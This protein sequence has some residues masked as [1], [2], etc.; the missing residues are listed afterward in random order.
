[1]STPD[2][3]PDGLVLVPRQPRAHIWVRDG[4]PTLTIISDA[5]DTFGIDWPEQNGPLMIFDASFDVT[6]TVV[7]A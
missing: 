1:M 3:S 6:V 4:R 2:F 7:G 5:D